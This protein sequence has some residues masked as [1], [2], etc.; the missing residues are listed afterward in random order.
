MSIRKISTRIA[1]DGEAEF[2][3]AVTSINSELR[4]MSSELKLVEAEYKG[5][6]NTAEALEKKL[7]ALQDMQ[8]AQTKKTEELKKATEN[9]KKAQEAY[10][11]KIDEIKSK[12][13][14]V[15]MGNH[16]HAFSKRPI[17]KHALTSKAAA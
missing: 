2:K 5:N 3:A 17:D 9:A 12:L 11:N 13:A 4:K 10:A 16:R 1:I 15:Q 6:A 14:A 7:K 8:E